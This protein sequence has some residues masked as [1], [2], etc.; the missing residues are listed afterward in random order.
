MGKLE[1][2]NAVSSL[3]RPAS[4]NFIAYKDILGKMSRNRMCWPHGSQRR[5]VDRFHVYCG[6]VYD[7]AGP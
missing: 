1:S 5:C 4:E 7:H 2:F 6:R 3:I